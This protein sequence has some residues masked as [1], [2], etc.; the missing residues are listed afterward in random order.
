MAVVTL[1]WAFPNL[2]RGVV[3]SFSEQV[4]GAL[5]SPVDETL[6]SIQKLYLA[7]DMLLHCMYYYIIIYIIA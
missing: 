5:F 4:I 2:A 7:Q 6:F 3:I 1:W